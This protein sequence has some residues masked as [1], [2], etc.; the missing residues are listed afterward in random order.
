MAWNEPGGNKNKDP[1]GNRGGNDGPPDLD[2]VFKKFM[3]KLNGILGS[4]GGSGRGTSSGSS[5]G[6][7]IA[8]VVIAAIIWLATGLYKIAEAERGVVLTFGKHSYTVESGLHW[9]IP[10]PIQQVLK[11]DV[12]N[13]H[14]Y[15]LKGTML[16][17]DQN[18]I[19]I[20]ITVQYQVGNAEDY[21]FEMRSP[22]RTLGEAT[23]SALRQHV[24]RSTM[25]YVFG[26]GREDIA[27][28]TQETTQ[29]ILDS[30]KSG[31]QILRVNMQEAKPPEA[32][33]A[34]FD[35]VTKSV[36]DEDKLKNQ[37]EAY[38]NEILPTARGESA[39]ML[40]QA[41]AYK[42]EVVARAEG[43]A[44]RFT[45]LYKEYRKAPA[46][47]R[48][49]MYIETVEAV[50]SQSSKIMVDVE[51]GNNMIYLPLDKMLQ[52][53]DVSGNAVKRAGRLIDNTRS[54][55]FDNTD[56]TNRS[57]RSREAR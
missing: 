8:L 16:T 12:S 2:E 17:Q 33:K 34:S 15:S 39:R 6:G 32:V 46:V 11:V 14:E 37:A 24:G 30:Y 19:D 53:S 43:E 13:I 25:D 56:F 26:D 42:Q 18:I 10:A 36:E 35:D 41:K 40:E 48:D 57:S 20:E 21:F 54:S 52:N 3:D 4:S 23:E 45:S 1:W 9:H 22:V 55:N 47:T 27:I 7:I 31:L 28:S 29:Q 49:R 51:G 44:K 50:L 38:R 5:K